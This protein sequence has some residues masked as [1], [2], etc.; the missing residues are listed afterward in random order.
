M[1]GVGRVWT[2]GL[3][4]VLAACGGGSGGSGGSVPVAPVPEVKPPVVEVKPPVVEVKPP[5]VVTPPYV[6]TPKA[7]T[8]T[9][10]AGYS[11]T[12]NFIARQ[13]VPFVG[14]AYLKVEADADVIDPAILIS[15]RADGTFDVGLKTSKTA[16]V[17]VYAGNLTISV[18]SDPACVNQLAGAPFKI[19]Y[20]IEVMSPKGTL[21]AQNYSPLSTLAGAPN[22]ET[23]QGNAQHTGFVPVTLVPSV[24]NER[25]RMTAS[26]VGANLHQYNPIATGGGQIY[27]SSSAAY[28]SSGSELSAYRESDGRKVWTQ[29]FGNLAYP[30]VNAPAYANSKVYMA[31][32][33]QGNGSMYAFDAASGKELFKSAMPG[34]FPTYLAPTLFNGSVYS[35]GGTFGGLYSFS[36]DTGVRNFVTTLA[37]QDRWTPAVSLNGVYAY[38]GGALRVIDPATGLVR[39]SLGEQVSSGFSVAVPVV[40]EDGFVFVK[41][42]AF[43]TLAKTI[44][45]TSDGVYGYNSAYGNRTL[46]AANSKTGELEARTDSTG[47]LLW[48]WALPSDDGPFASDVLLTNN[49]VFVSSSTKTYAIDRVS[50]ATVWTYPL[51]GSLALSANG[52]LYIKAASVIQAINLK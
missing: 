24:F 22:W 14:V 52:V 9:Y 20:T 17:G 16:K 48:K 46:F 7:L 51:G 34:Q 3:M 2:V 21:T 5:V 33:Q 37:Q 40:G 38:V 11:Q 42:L 19:P 41:Q 39:F 30:S 35:N 43:N 18:C 32:G 6:V 12:L 15:P 45:W 8:A 23:V 26:A 36:A 50:H 49:L 29:S 1:Q 31:A 27:V 10:L 47:A 44:A 13:S 4:S 25:W 28:G